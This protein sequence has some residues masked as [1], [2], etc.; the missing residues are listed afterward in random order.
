MVNNIQN[1]PPSFG[2]FEN[3]TANSVAPSSDVMAVIMPVVPCVFS[4]TTARYAAPSGLSKFCA[5]SPSC[6]VSM[7]VGSCAIVAA[8]ARYIN[9]KRCIVNVICDEKEAFGVI[10]TRRTINK[11]EYD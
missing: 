1:G 5:A 2:R 8:T 3:S 9:A 10:R 4:P 6:P 7:G 11:S